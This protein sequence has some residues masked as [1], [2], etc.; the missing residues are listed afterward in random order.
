MTALRILF[1]ASEVH[2]YAKTGGLA[3]ACGALAQ[4]VS[5]LGHDIRLVLPLYKSI[6]PSHFQ[7]SVAIPGLCVQTGAGEF[8]C[9]IWETTL[10]HSHVPIYFIER[11]DLFYRDGIYGDSSGDFSDN[12]LRF[13]FLSRAALQICATLDWEPHV[14]HCN[15]WQTSLLPIY[16]KTIEHHR[17][18]NTASLLTIHNVGYQGIFPA[19]AM[20]TAGLSMDLFHYRCLEFWGRMNFLKGGILNATLLSTVSRGY[21]REIQTPQFGNQLDDLLF[22]RRRSLF[23]IINGV[24]YHEWNPE[25]DPLIV[26]NYNRF[27]LDGKKAC[28]WFLQKRFNLPERPEVPLIGLVSRIT[29]QKG[30]DI[31]AEVLS[32]IL[33]TMDV[34]IVLLG[35]G[36]SWAYDFFPKMMHRYPDKFSCE[37]GFHNELAHQITAGA[38]FFLMPSRYEPCGLNQLYSLIYGTLPIVRAVGGLDDTVINL[39]ETTQVGNGFKFYDLTPDAIYHTVRWAL[40]IWYHHPEVIELMQQQAMAERFDWESS[41]YQYLQ[42]Y[43]EA[44]R[45]QYLLTI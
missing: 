33:D 24:D 13:S 4:A 16:L 38:D 45:R 10:P 42:L 11:D 43:R 8:W 25:I 39:S 36:E 20:A 6:Q 3:D 15:D 12:A 5:K 32:G 1:V 27:H 17:F 18:P 41:A 40:R 23:G 21:A 29:Y 30:I 44:L 2:P 22:L 31:F 14:V 7:L 19:E 34:Q 9:K 37:M 26:Q 35:A 28:K